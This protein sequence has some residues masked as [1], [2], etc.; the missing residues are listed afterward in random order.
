VG[1]GTEGCGVVRTKVQDFVG[2]GKAVWRR[3]AEQREAV[4]NVERRRVV[5]GSESTRSGP[6][7]S[8]SQCRASSGS[9][10]HVDGNQRAE[11]LLDRNPGR[12]TCE[13]LGQ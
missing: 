9:G 5:D 12:V 6:A 1:G 10:E 2:S 11:A 3:V 8:G 7:W 4:R 13:P